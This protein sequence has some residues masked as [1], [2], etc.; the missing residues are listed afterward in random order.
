M[1]HER[2]ITIR[3]LYPHMS[4]EQLAV[5]EANLRRYVAVLLRIHDRLKREGKTWPPP[6]KP[7][8]LTTSRKHP[9]IPTERS[10]VT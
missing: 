3:D 6:L 1:E 10:N 2:E 8:D 5:V 7:G 9:I 4:D